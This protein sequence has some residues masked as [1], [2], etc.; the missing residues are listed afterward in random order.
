[1][2]VNT[3]AKQLSQ[4]IVVLKICCE[5]SK[6]E[7]SSECQTFVTFF[8]LFVRMCLP[9]RAIS[10]ESRKNINNC[11]IRTTAGIVVSELA[12]TCDWVR[13]ENTG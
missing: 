11:V 2:R 6:P 12:E 10:Y 9:S 7:L 1:M 3:L 4:C 8:V 13:R 5:V